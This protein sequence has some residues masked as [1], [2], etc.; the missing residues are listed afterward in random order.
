MVTIVRVEQTPF[1]ELPHRTSGP[2]GN[3][4]CHR[5][6]FHRAWPTGLPDGTEGLLMEIPKSSPIWRSLSLAVP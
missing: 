1:H 6:A 5:L 4:L 3:P 2:S